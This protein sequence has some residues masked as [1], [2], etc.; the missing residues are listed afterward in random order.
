MD[1][2]L[3]I[4][5]SGAEM[6]MGS[7]EPQKFSEIWPTLWAGNVWISCHGSEMEL[8]D[9]GC[10]SIAFIPGTLEVQILFLVLSWTC[11][12]ALDKANNLHS[13]HIFNIKGPLSNGDFA[14]QLCWC[15]DCLGGL[16]LYMADVGIHAALLHFLGLLF[17]CSLAPGTSYR[18]QITWS[19]V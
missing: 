10:G 16:W 4:N 18:G 9:S 11:L 8:L 12:G 6:V 1:L 15:T 14:A 2:P 5:L 13:T 3:R 17:Y 7:L 19:A